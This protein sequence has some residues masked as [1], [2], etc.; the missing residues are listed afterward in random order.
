MA[1]GTVKWFN[2]DKGF[3]FI[4]P[5]D[6]GDDLFVHHSEI[7]TQGY[8]SLTMF[9][10]TQ[11]VEKNLADMTGHI[12]NV[13]TG[14]V[15]YAIRDSV[16]NGVQIKKNDFIG[17]FD[18]EIVAC[19]QDRLHVAIQTSLAMLEPKSEI[20]TI[21]YGSDVDTHEVDLLIDAIEEASSVELETISGGQDI[22]S[23]II[24]VE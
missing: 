15:T 9:D 17:I 3:G 6:G 24:S 22:Y 19:E 4:A 7:R 14:E 8:A 1:K 20:V 11:N 21:M 18:G 23:Y 10:A 5:D 13:K 12:R 2:A 16:N